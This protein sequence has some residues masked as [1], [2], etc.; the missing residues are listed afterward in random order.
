MNISKNKFIITLKTAVI[1]VFMSAFWLSC[2]QM[3]TIYGG[4]ED[5]ASPVLKRSRPDIYSTN[6]HKKKVKM[7][8]D[9]F[10]TLE[11]IDQKFLMSPPPLEKDPKI[12]TRGK[13]V[14]VKLKEP[15]RKDTTYTLQFFDCIQDFHE[16]NHEPDFDFVFSTGQVCDSFAVSGNVYD[17]ELLT[18][19]EDIL[20]GLY[21]E[22]VTGED[23]CV[24]KYRPNY[25]TRTDSTGHFKIKNIAEGKYKI[26]VLKDINETKRY[27][28]EDEKISFINTI[29]EP[30]A[31]TLTKIDSLTAGTILHSGT[32]RRRIIDTL[33]NDTVIIQQVLYTTPNNINLFSFA[34]VK[35]VQYISERS[36][37]LRQRFLLVFNKS[38]EKD[39][40][41][42]TYVEDTLRSPE[43]VYDFNYNRDSLYVWLLDTADVRN[44]TLSLRVTYS[45]IDSLQNPITETDTVR[46]RYA[47]KKAG[48]GNDGKKQNTKTPNLVDS[49]YFSVTSNFKGDFDQNGVASIQI[50]IPIA[51]I[52]TSRIKLY[53]LQDSSFVEDM[54]Q[55]LIKAVRLDSADYRLV[56]KRGIYGD[57][58]FY[59]VDTVVGNDWFTATYS[60][61][62]DTVDIHI[63]DTA[64]VKKG[65]FKNTLKYFNEY[66]LGEIQKLRDTVPTAIVPQKILSYS[67]PSRDSIIVVL[68]KKPARAIQ[69]EAINVNT[70]YEQWIDT[71]FEK[72]RVVFLIRDTAAIYKDTLAVKFNTFD[73]YVKNRKGDKINETFFKDTLFAIYKVKTQKVKSVTRITNDTMQFVFAYPLQD[74]PV[75]AFVRPAKKVDTVGVD[76]V[77]TLGVNLIDTLDINLVDTLGIDL[78]DTSGIDLVDTLGIDLEDTLGINLIDTLQVVEPE[79][80]PEPEPIVEPVRIVQPVVEEDTV[81]HVFWNSMEFSEQRDTMW[82][83]LSDY[84]ASRDT[85]RYSVS[86]LSPN[87]LDVFELVTDTLSSMRLPEAVE[88]KN[89]ADRRRRS[90]IGLDAQRQKEE[91][92]KN[93]IQAVLRIPLSF[94]IENDTTYLLNK[95]II[96][97]WEPEKRYEIQVDDS[98]FTSILNTPNLYFTSKIQVRP[99]DFYGSMTINLLNTGNVEHYPD[100]D[101]DLP[102]FK[103]LDTAR[104]RIRKR[105][106]VVTDSTADFTAISQGQLL[107][108]L[109]TDKG[110][111][112]YM[113]TANCDESVLFDYILPGDYYLRIIYD[114]NANR[115]WDTGDYLKGVYPER[116]I[117]YPRKQTVKSKWVVDVLWKL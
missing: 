90:N 99:D 36:R 81:F 49:L 41:S 71:V 102:P 27:D 50:P 107:V 114:R 110:E 34:Q 4:E 84:A 91:D 58:I 2:A 42:I 3:G 105:T 77:D 46:L 47:V 21:S 11:N 6:F 18:K 103:D 113:K 19:E 115:K 96:Y 61:N 35:T 106:P 64:M 33:L 95:N 16:Q 117:A 13:K 69:F 83:V 101:E 88:Q 60:P 7:K 31:Q 56:F 20:V 82:L 67:R 22:S 38:V 59:P 111:I 76:L 86:Y 25:I 92:K 104:V 57:I 98:A 32:P 87:R 29:V 39:T 53:E 51:E 44:D 68:E 75:F 30:E 97:P 79:P 85:L 43:M 78:I 10:F 63:N 28:L 73:R 80:E 12:K 74:N 52:D 40:V 26:F 54:N 23:S 1:A 48:K 17:A 94:N 62:R 8:F 65:R 5:T 112:K 93:M 108:C 116:V 9:E 14:I 15:L 66:Y 100:I 45:T 55:K 89:Q 109:C 24:I 72:E 70:T 37:E